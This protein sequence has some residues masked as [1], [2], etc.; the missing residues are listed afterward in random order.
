[1]L[2]AA[3]DTMPPATAV[4]AWLPLTFLNTEPAGA[5]KK[6]LGND[7]ACWVESAGYPIHVGST[8]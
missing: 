8:A 5:S 7:V 4:M 2:A 3:I 1:V 6:A